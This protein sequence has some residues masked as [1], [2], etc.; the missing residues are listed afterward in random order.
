MKCTGISPDAGFCEGVLPL[1]DL[2]EGAGAPAENSFL[3]K[4][5][6]AQL[7]GAMERGEGT[8]EE[9]PRGRRGRCRAWAAASEGRSRRRRTSISKAERRRASS[10]Q[11]TRL[12]RAAPLQCIAHRRLT[13]RER[14]LAIW[15]ARRLNIRI[16]SHCCFVDQRGPLWLHSDGGRLPCFRA[17]PETLRRILGMQRH[18]AR[19]PFEARVVA[20]R[21]QW[22]RDQKSLMR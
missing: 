16:S 9:S 12:P 13:D 15:F 2:D 18:W 5:H 6:S 19:K 3:I 21:S 17:A 10:A 20:L 1:R 7:E 11:S 22:S 14:F 4:V 8:A